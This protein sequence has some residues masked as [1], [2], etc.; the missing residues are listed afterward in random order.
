[1]IGEF[2][3]KNTL[4]DSG[5]NINVISRANA[6]RFGIKKIEPYYTSMTLVDNS[7][8]K[9]QG[10]IKDYPLLVDGTH[11]FGSFGECARG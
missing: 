9:P 5:A 7:S 3:L 1:M 10:L 4:V 6:R 2:E 11:G 8:T